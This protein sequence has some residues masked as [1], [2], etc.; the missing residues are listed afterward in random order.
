VRTCLV[1]ID[2]VTVLGEIFSKKLAFFERLQKDCD[3]FEEQDKSSKKHPD[4]DNGET[5]SERI[6][7]A[8]HT[9]EE[10]ND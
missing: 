4:D 8:R 1:C 6:A 5:C 2:E 7:F 9:M 10:S 3:Q